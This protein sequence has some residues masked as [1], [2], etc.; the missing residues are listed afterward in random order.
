MADETGP[1]RVYLPS[2]TRCAGGQ[3]E[4]SHGCLSVLQVTDDLA[5]AEELLLLVLDTDQ[6]DIRHTFPLHSRAVAFAGAVLIDLAL[7]NRIDTDVESLMVLDSTPL[8]NDLLDPTLADIAADGEPRNTAFWITK[9][10]E[11]GDEIREKALAR[12]IERGILEA[13]SG[14]QIFLSPGVFRPRQYKT[15]DGRT[16]E[17]VQLRIMRA[18]FSDDIPDPRDIVIISLA[19][20]CGVFESILSRDELAQV[21][22]RIDLICRL[23]L[24]GLEVT[25][26]I[27]QIEAPPPSPSYVRPAAEIPRAAGLPLLGNAFG[28]AR[29]VREFLLREYQRHGP[30]FRVGAL[31]HRWIALVGPEANV[32]AARISPTHFRSWEPY[33]DFGA[34]LGAIGS[35]CPWTAPSINVCAGYW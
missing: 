31:H 8:G 34:A 23:D 4:S 25:E 17:E 33:S 35:C 3:Q 30:I 12:L 19:S 15:V 16:T 24:I 11:R 1:R 2:V 14:G 18:L 7:Q 29:D 10:S 20:A 22:E 6:G 26:A 9:L 21:Q 28:M 5:T 32:F 27:R 13:D